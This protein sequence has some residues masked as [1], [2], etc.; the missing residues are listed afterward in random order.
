[1]SRDEPK[2]PNDTAEP[3]EADENP[4]SKL[5]PDFGLAMIKGLETGTLE[6]SENGKT[7][8]MNEAREAGIASSGITF[9]PFTNSETFKIDLLSTANGT[10][11]E[12]PTVNA[13]D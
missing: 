8:D 13:I 4:W 2:T 7:I 1:M 12:K 3:D 11:S 5:S 10:F 6:G 9:L